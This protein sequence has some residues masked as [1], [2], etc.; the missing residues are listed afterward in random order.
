MCS[1]HITLGGLVVV[2]WWLV[3]PALSVVVIQYPAVVESI[4]FNMW[5]VVCF[6]HA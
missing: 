6:V 1:S 5:H 2:F 3:Q 4:F